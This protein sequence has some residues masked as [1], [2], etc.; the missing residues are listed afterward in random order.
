MCGLDERRHWAGEGGAHWW[1]LLIGWGLQLACEGCRR[2]GDRQGWQEIRRCLERGDGPREGLALLRR[3]DPHGMVSGWLGLDP[4][5]PRGWRSHA[6]SAALLRRPLLLIGGWHDP[7]LR[8][9][10]DLWRRSRAAAGEPEL[11][12]GAWSHLNWRGGVDERQLAFFRR[13]L[14][15]TAAAA[16][17]EPP[18]PPPPVSLQCLTRG[19]WRNPPPSSLADPPAVAASWTLHSAGLAAVRSD[20]GELRCGAEG[21]GGG[22]WL[23]HDPWRPVPGRGGHL[24]GEADLA[25]RGDLDGRTDVACF[26]SAPLTEELEL[27]GEPR[28]VIAVVAE[29][30]GF[31]LCAALSVLGDG[32]APV[33][34]L[35]TGVVRQRA[36]GQPAGGTLELRLQPLRATLAVGQ[37]L[38]L[39]LAGSAWPQIAVHSGQAEPPPGPCGPDHRVISLHLRLE[40]ARLWLAPLIGAD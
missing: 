7:H 13:H 35:S 10:L 39:S 37:R 24:G 12:I 27:L 5:E 14:G 21:G 22:V 29:P 32:A 17:P 1:A 8:G 30:G 11:L 25:D 26:S 34:Q 15:E 6:P 38:R 40:G 23:V 3:H 28:L 2:R 18:P 4:A 9:V 33:R 36:A 20:E 31:D 19:D 16:K